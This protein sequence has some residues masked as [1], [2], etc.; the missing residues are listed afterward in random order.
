MGMWHMQDLPQSPLKEEDHTQ[1]KS[2]G[3]DRSPSPAQLLEGAQ[4]LGPP[5]AG[6]TQGLPWIICCMTTKAEWTR[7]VHSQ[8]RSSFT[9]LGGASW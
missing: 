9:C 3:K 5:N 2:F 7:N 1:R 6:E 4:S 8:T